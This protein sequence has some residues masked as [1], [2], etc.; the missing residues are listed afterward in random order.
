MV[1]RANKGEVA[2]SNPGE[3][4]VVEE[5]DALVEVADTQGCVPETVRAT[6][7][8][9]LEIAK[10]QFE[11][12]HD[13]LTGLS[14][15]N[16]F[17]TYL[18]SVLEKTAPA[19]TD[20]VVAAAAVQPAASVS[21]L[22]L[23]IDH[24]K[25]VN[26][27]HGHL[28]G[29]LVLKVV[30]ERL[31]RLAGTIE[32][33]QHERNTLRVARPG[34]EEFLVAIAGQHGR[35]ELNQ[36]AERFR[37][38]IADSILPSDEEWSR[39]TPFR[40]EERRPPADRKIAT[41]I[42]V[43]TY[44]R[45]STRGGEQSHAQLKDRADT[46]LY[47]AKAGGRNVVRHFDDILG[48]LG[49]VIHQHPDTKV[50][51][52]DIGRKVDLQRGSE[53][54]VFHPEF[55]GDVPVIKDDGRT[56]KHLGKYPRVNSGSI[57]VF[58]VD[59]EISFARSTGNEPIQPDSSLEMVP[60]GSI[61]HLVEDQVTPNPDLQNVYAIE[62]EIKALISRNDLFSIV[63]FS[64]D[65]LQELASARGSNYVNATLAEL[66]RNIRETLS[67][68][69]TIVQID[70]NF[71]V[72]CQLALGDPDAQHVRANRLIEAMDAKTKKVARFGFG[73][74]YSGKQ[75]KNELSDRLRALRCINRGS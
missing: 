14:N 47:R 74:F 46:A 7:Q 34:G 22:A 37:T 1:A 38:I 56:R 65:N 62:K 33:E 36:I 53:F 10:A 8:F 41:S 61:G 49:R 13:L 39:L 69:S 16:S 23:D 55:T 45:S 35:G 63:V 75:W 72:L 12:A 40:P 43:A 68:V 67:G 17:D 70:T 31:Q 25:Q 21:V 2:G 44:D 71:I 15:R 20:Q 4:F 29:D 58:H 9:A 54:L 30:A 19:P 57:V 24:F 5:L 28:Y 42:G 60:L 32:T 51:T 27:T 48:K 59:D 26:D 66:F 3:Y 11:A 6:I 73:I 18:A 64:L 52:I 50:V